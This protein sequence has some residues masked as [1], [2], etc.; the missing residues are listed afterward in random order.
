[1]AYVVPTPVL[2]STA[3]RDN[4]VYWMTM[5]K[6]N[7]KVTGLVQLQTEM[8][9]WVPVKPIVA[10]GLLVDEMHCSFQMQ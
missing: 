6:R 2:K 7:V 4:T 1:M 3:R 10:A 8:P 9:A 5:G